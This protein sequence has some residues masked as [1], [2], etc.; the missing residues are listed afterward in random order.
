VRRAIDGID[1]AVPVTVQTLASSTSLE[2][3]MRQAGTWLM[4]TMGAVGLL[5]AAIGL[6]G[7]MAYVVAT[8]TAEIGIRL[9][10]GAS[11]RRI[12]RDVMRKA[13]AIVGW[14]IGIGALASVGLMPVFR[15]FL[16]GVSPF[17]PLVFGGAAV[18]LM[19]MGLVASYLPARRSSELDPMIALRRG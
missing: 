15:T 2:M 9:A 8:R 12:R 10:L 11:S 18:L 1:R 17:D 16:A 6:Y 4:G 19:L 13:F 5:L 7:V 14:G 3:T